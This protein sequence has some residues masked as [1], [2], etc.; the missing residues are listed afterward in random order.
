M[1]G[2]PFD[3]L[4]IRYVIDLRALQ[5]YWIWFDGTMKEKILSEWNKFTE[6]WESKKFL[7]NLNCLPFAVLEHKLFKRAN[8]LFHDQLVLNTKTMQIEAR[9]G[10][11]ELQELWK[12]LSEVL[13]KDFKLKWDSRIIGDTRWKE[14]SCLNDG[15]YPPEIN[16]MLAQ[17]S[18]TTIG[19][20]DV[21]KWNHISIFRDFWNKTRYI[22]CDRNSVSNL[23]LNDPLLFRKW[24]FDFFNNFWFMLLPK[25]NPPNSQ[26]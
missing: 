11:I 6:E 2:I 20:E 25:I 4:P 21:Y 12:K 17:L 22:I 19:D 18:Q 16:W 14:E 8:M 3:A 23:N 15:R 10:K 26:T 24:S 9:Q 5:I 7:F 13:R 1:H